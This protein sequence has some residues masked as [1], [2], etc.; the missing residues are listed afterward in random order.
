MIVVEGLRELIA[1]LDQ[2]AAAMPRE[3]RA[4]VAKGALH[5]KQDWR[6]RW[7][8]HPHIP[9]LPYAISYD[10][11]VGPREIR[12]EIGPDKGKAQGPLGNII[13]FGTANNTP[14]PGGLPALDAEAPRYERAL[15]DLAARLAAG[16]G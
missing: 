6:R 14:I 12:A 11:T 4:V 3:V 2:A 8:G 9:V 16:H 15:S 13:E 10:V 7:S 5:V 1:D